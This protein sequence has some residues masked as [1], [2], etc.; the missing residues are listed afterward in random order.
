MEHER[1]RLF[2]DS[3]GRSERLGRSLTERADRLF[4]RGAV[5]V[6]GFSAS[7]PGY[8]LE[9]GGFNLIPENWIPAKPG[10]SWQVLLD[11]EPAEDLLRRSAGNTC[12]YIIG[13]N[14]SGKSMLLRQLAVTRL[15]AGGH[16]CA[17]AFGMTDRF[18]HGSQSQRY[19]NYTYLGARTSH[20]AVDP[21]KLAQQAARL[22][23]EI[24]QSPR[25]LDAFNDVSGLLSF[26]AEHY[27]LPVDARTDFLQKVE[28]LEDAPS[29]M[30]LRQ[31]KLGM[32]RGEND[33][34][35]F[36]LLSS[37]EQQLL[38]L[39]ARLVANASHGTVFVVDEPE[40]SLHVAW[41]KQLPVVFRRVSELFLVDIVVATHAPVVI[42][43]ATAERDFCFTARGGVLDVIS[44]KDKRSVETALFEGFGTYTERNREVQERCAEIVAEAITERN[45]G[46][47][48]DPEEFASRLKRMEHV[49]RRTTASDSSQSA[50]RDLRLIRQ[51]LAAVS[52]LMA[53]SSLGAS[54]AKE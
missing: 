38:L 37:G 45:A 7:V 2:D 35:P 12:I 22:M 48:V 46:R 51:A 41:Q 3:A 1:G 31:W 5:A 40:T 16:V 44:R 39:L 27:L 25:R 20:S 52:E 4:G 53:G 26:G 17:I 8:Q 28:R 14:G 9:S 21:R 10:R 29:D 42:A 49:I 32:K 34:V 30:D 36:D 24:Y 6:D 18:L 43:A 19:P 47:V 11:G 13:D 15:D 23:L 33:I 50:A 54:D